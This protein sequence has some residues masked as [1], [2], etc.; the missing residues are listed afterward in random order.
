M[1]RHTLAAMSL[2]CIITPILASAAA[3][4]A[5]AKMPEGYKYD[6]AG[7]LARVES[8]LS[9][10][11]TIKARFNQVAPDGS[12]QTG[13]FSLKRPGKMRW[14]YDPPVPVL[15]VSN[16]KTITYYDS[17]MGQVNYIDVDDTLAGFL[18]QQDIKLESAAT[19]VTDFKAAADVIRV[20]IAQNGKANEGQL[21]L[22]FVDR[23]LQL[24][25][26]TITDATG[27]ATRVQLQ[28]AEYG[29]ALPDSLFVFKDPRGVTPRKGR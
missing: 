3:N 10:L 13:T 27:A 14:D 18:T 21:M 28:G 1:K 15:L 4:A 20:T 25:F 24:K 29:V 12:V 8:Y 16:G 2:L 19:R 26:M 6:R 9:G 22:E 23:P 7:T 11:T 17:D 5:P